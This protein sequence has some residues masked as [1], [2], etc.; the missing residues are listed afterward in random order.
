MVV[1]TNAN[2]RQDDTAVRRAARLAAAAVLGVFLVAGCMTRLTNDERT[3]VEFWGTVSAE[4]EVA[5][6]ELS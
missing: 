1:R 6:R 3:K 2:R 5:V 4:T